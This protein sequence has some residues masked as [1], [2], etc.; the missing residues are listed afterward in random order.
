[1]EKKLYTVMY[2]YTREIKN[3]RY[4][5][6]KGMEYSLFKQQM[7]FFKHNFNVITMEQVIEAWNSPNGSLPERALLL[8]FDDGYVDN[9][10]YAFPV[11]KEY[12][13]QGS[14]FI[15]GKT[16]NENVL[17][18]VNKVHFILAASDV[19]KVVN[20]LF[21]LLDQYRGAKWEYLSNE[22]LFLKYA[23]ANRFDTKETIFVKRVLQTVLPEEL[24]NILCSKL[25]EEFVD[26]PEEAFSRELYMNRDQLKM[27]KREGMFIGLHGYDHYWMGNLSCEQMHK[28]IDK[29]IMVMGEFID[30]NSWVL[31]YPYG[32]YNN[33]VL[34]YIEQKGCKLGMTTRVGVGQ[35]GIDGRFEIP[36]FDCNDFPPKSTRY[37]DFE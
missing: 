28:D 8:T 10:L 34:S 20:R 2:H 3:S 17:L 16:I 25:F 37:L 36:R 9:F 22:E 31:N 11:L 29:M 21:A 14:F 18:D 33:E 27:M 24:R 6:V 5:N 13:F 19:R 30:N 4:P 1:M 26:V 23:V 15:P 35:I 32:S 12:G 7:E